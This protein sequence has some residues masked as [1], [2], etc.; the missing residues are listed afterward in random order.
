MRK[1]SL[2][3]LLVLILVQSL[4]SQEMLNISNTLYLHNPAVTGLR[5]DLN[6]TAQHFGFDLGLPDISKGIQSFNNSRIKLDGRI[7][8]F[9]KLNQLNLNAGIAY[10]RDEYN[11]V[12]NENNWSVLASNF[13]K[14]KNG[15]LFSLGFSYTQRRI[16]IDES[17][18]VF[19]QSPEMIETKKLDRFS[20]GLFY[21]N[22]DRTFI[23]G[24][25]ASREGIEKPFSRIN[26]SLETYLFY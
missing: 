1:N 26:M 23:A 22:E 10:E 14:L 3:L 25:G 12:S 13:F 6:L 11:S 20:T 8:L 2:L 9:E 21:E 19:V 7:P 5:S 18:L 17:Y 4:Y 16:G 24:L 15:S